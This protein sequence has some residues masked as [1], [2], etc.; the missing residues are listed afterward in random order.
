MRK[1]ILTVSA[2]LFLFIAAALVIIGSGERD[3]TF[4]ILCSAAVPFL[5]TSYW[6]FYSVFYE[7]RINYGNE[8]FISNTENSASVGVFYHKT[9]SLPIFLILFGSVSLAIAAGLT[10]AAGNNEDIAAGLL[11]LSFLYSFS[12][13]LF[14]S[15]KIKNRI[16]SDETSPQV[17]DGETGFKIAF[18]FASI[19]TLGLFPLVYFIIRLMKKKPD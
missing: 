16:K 7:K 5:F 10:A 18:F 6:N 9:I 13:T 12:I 17:S 11:A 8:Y 3:S 19:A 4:I 15:I 1:I 2:F 14:F